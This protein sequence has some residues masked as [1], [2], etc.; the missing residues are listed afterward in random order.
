MNPLM[1]AAHTVGF[2]GS[3]FATYEDAAVWN[4]R[5]PQEPDNYSHQTDEALAVFREWFEGFAYQPEPA[6]TESLISLQC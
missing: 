4:N 2:L 1:V 3:W 5:K 6:E